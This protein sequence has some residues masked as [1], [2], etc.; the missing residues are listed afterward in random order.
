[1]ERAGIWVLAAAL[2]GFG[3]MAAALT[4]T[5]TGIKFTLAGEGIEVELK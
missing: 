1:M 5:Q 4:G 2:L 3:G